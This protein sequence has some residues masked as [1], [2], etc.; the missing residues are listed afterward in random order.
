M[1]TRSVMQVAVV[2]VALL[3]GHSAAGREQEVVPSERGSTRDRDATTSK[4]CQLNSAEIT[5][6]SFREGDEITATV[7]VVCNQPVDDAS[8]FVIHRPSNKGKVLKDAALKTGKN[9]LR[10]S[11]KA[12]QGGHYEVRV[13]VADGGLTGRIDTAPVAWTAHKARFH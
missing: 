9:V 10:L 7:V 5:P 3:S 4:N 2:V 1:K 8:V 11:P 12:G 6:T 13:R